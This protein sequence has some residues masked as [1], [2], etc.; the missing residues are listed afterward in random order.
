MRRNRGQL[1]TVPVESRGPDWNRPY[2]ATRRVA[3]TRKLLLTPGDPVRHLCF[4]VSSVETSRR[5]KELTDEL[6]RLAANSLAA[7]KDY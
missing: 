1:G 2:G 4:W 5:I 3:W 6:N 7:R